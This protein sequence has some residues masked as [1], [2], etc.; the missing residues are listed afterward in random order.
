[1]LEI[2]FLG[3]GTSTGVP[4]IRCDCHVC[5]STDPHDKR[6]RASA[7]VRYRGLNLLLDCGPDFRQQMLT[8]SNNDLDALLITHIHYDHVGGIDDLRAYCA[9]GDFPIYARQDVIDDLKERLPYCF[10]EHL[11]MGVPR[12]AVTPIVENVPFSIGDVEILPLPVMHY[13][14]PILGFKI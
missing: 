10:A 9:D 8:A 13:K 14:L 11:Y 6:L 5:Q 7:I 4:Q 1:M 2:E 3:T 12:L